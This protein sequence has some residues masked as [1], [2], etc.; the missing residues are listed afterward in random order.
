MNT[1]LKNQLLFVLGGLLATSASLAGND[2]A[3]FDVDAKLGYQTDSNVGIADLDT[4]SGTADSATTYG[5]VLKASLPIS[6]RWVSRLWLRL[7]RH[8]L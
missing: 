2:K 8:G 5:V 3:S 4:N 7:Q 6:K 1:L